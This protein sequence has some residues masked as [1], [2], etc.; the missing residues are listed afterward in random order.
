MDGVK[1][2]PEQDETPG[3]MRLLRHQVALQKK[4]LRD[5][6]FVHACCIHTHIVDEAPLEASTLK[7]Q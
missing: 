6:W 1:P 4:I 7:T 2:L 3:F 5:F